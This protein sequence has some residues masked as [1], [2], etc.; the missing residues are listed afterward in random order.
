MSGILP[1]TN[2]AEVTITSHFP[3]VVVEANSGQ[4]QRLNYMGHYYKLQVNYPSLEVKSAKE[5]MGFLQAQKGQLSYFDVEV[6]YY[7]D[8]SGVYSDL[9][10]EYNGVV[11]PT[12]TT[13]FTKSKS[14]SIIE[15]STN[16]QNTHYN[17]LMGDFLSVGDYIQFFNHSKVYQITEVSNPIDVG[18]VSHGAFKISPSLVMDVPAG[19]AII[20]R[21]VRWRVFLDDKVSQMSSGLLGRTS[22]A[23]NL[24]EDI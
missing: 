15:Y 3:T 6:P 16:F 5:I 8:S 11:D 21:G 20:A 9:A 18:S 23:L 13:R 2:F 14:N 22:I 1:N 17:Q 4:T 7:S 10:I 19:T 12:L 24:R